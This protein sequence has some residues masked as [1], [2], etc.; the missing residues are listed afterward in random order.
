MPVVEDLKH[1]TEVATGLGR[2]D[3]VDIVTS[4]RKPQLF[5]FRDDGETPNNPHLPLVHYRSAV[6]LDP[7]FDPAATFE[8]LFKHYGWTGAWRDGVYDFNHFHTRTHEVLGVARG[9][10]RV[11]FGGAQGRTLALKAGDV[12]VLPAGTGHRL[13]SGSRDLL[14]VGAYPDNGGKYNEPKPDDVD[15]KRARADIAKVKLP[16]RDPVYGA[17]AG[18]HLVWKNRE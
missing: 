5:S 15:A 8:V 9:T 1:I 3:W 13:I 18:L 6:R 2:P 4:S 17:K 10:V 16:K 11:R 7:A 14:V 12:V